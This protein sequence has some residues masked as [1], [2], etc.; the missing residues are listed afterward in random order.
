MGAELWFAAAV[1]GPQILGAGL[2]RASRPPSRE[3][4]SLAPV[5]LAAIGMAVIQAT[6]GAPAALLA[7]PAAVALAVMLV[8][9]GRPAGNC[10]GGALAAGFAP[11]VWCAL[12]LA[13]AVWLGVE[14]EFGP[15]LALLTAAAAVIAHWPRL[16]G[17][18][19]VPDREPPLPWFLWSAGH[20]GW[21]VMVMVSGL[22]WP[23]LAFPLASQAMTLGIGIFALDGGAE[24][25][26]GGNATR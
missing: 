23:F 14:D 1:A 8:G 24:R 16:A 9:F 7:A 19:A 3:R 20:G 22:P 26:E 12:M 11:L 6:L 10:P 21:A 5:A 13:P 17:V 25:R 4:G 18:Y 2:H 15:L